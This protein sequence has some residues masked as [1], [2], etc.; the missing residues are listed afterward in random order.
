M[1]K[2]SSSLTNESDLQTCCSI[3]VNI[4]SISLKSF[5]TQ[6]FV[7][8]LKYFNRQSWYTGK[9]HKNSLLNIKIFKV[10]L[11]EKT[12]VQDLKMAYILCYD[13]I[14]YDIM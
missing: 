14:R 13:I 7:S 5:E 8:Q 12:C 9:R 10:H 4:T 2:L 6:V 1:H 11:L 3:N